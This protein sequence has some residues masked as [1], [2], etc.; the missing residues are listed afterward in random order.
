MTYK[1]GA[2]SLR[3]LTDVHPALVQV[4]LRAIEL[5]TQDFSVHEGLRSLKT[6]KEYVAK[7][8]SRTMNSMH[9]RQPDGYSHAV[10]LVPWAGG[11]M[12]WEWPLIY[13]IAEAMRQAA[14]ENKVQLRWGGNWGN[15]TITSDPPE[16]LVESYVKGR[17]QAFID[18]PHYE[19]LRT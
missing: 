1:L 3:R 2:G 14:Q 8:V 4:V 10:D 18:G 17:R 16:E 5:T 6:Q 15:L 13:P 12:R 7:G 11:M 9:L 19:L